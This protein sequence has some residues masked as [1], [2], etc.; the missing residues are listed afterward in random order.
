MTTLTFKNFEYNIV[1]IDPTIEVAGDGSTPATALNTFPNSLVNNTCYIIRR[2]AKENYAELVNATNANLNNLIIMGMPKSR[3]SDEYTILPQ[4]VKD[5]WGNDTE[6]Y[7][8][9]LANR[10]LVILNIKNFSLLNTFFFRNTED[11]AEKSTGK[12]AMFM[13]YTSSSNEVFYRDVNVYI[14]GCKFGH[15]YYD[16]SDATYQEENET[17][18]NNYARS[19]MRYLFFGKVNNLEIQD[20]TF[21]YTCDLGS[22]SLL[23]NFDSSGYMHINGDRSNNQGVNAAFIFTPT[24]DIILK[25]LVLNCRYAH[26]LKWGIDSSPNYMNYLSDILYGD[27]SY[28]CSRS[29]LGILDIRSNTAKCKIKNI[30]INHILHSDCYLPCNPLLINSTS[31]HLRSYYGGT[32]YRT[33][34]LYYPHIDMSDIDIYMSKF[35]GANPTTS[36]TALFNEAKPTNSTLSNKALERDNSYRLGSIVLHGIFEGTVKN[37]NADLTYAPTMSVLT[38]D[39]WGGVYNNCADGKKLTIKNINVNT[40][41]TEENIVYQTQDWNDSYVL[42]VLH[43]EFRSGNDSV[44]MRN[45][46][47]INPI[48]LENIYINSPYGGALNL[49]HAEIKN[50]TIIGNTKFGYK[51]KAK[52]DSLTNCCHHKPA[53]YIMNEENDIEIKDLIFDTTK[54][55]GTITNTPQVCYDKSLSKFYGNSSI[56]IENSN[57]LCFEETVNTTSNYDDKGTVICVNHGQEGQ[58]LQVTKNGKINSCSVVR[59]GSSANASLRFILNGI[60]EEGFYQTIKNDNRSTFTIYPESTG[61]ISVSFFLLSEQPLDNEDL[62]DNFKIE[63]SHRGENGTIDSVLSTSI[64]EDSSTWTGLAGGY[65]YKITRQLNIT[66]IENPLEIEVKNCISGKGA[67]YLDPDIQVEEQV[68]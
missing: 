62:T 47:S 27:D 57:A 18:P 68:M 5:A 48:Y 67:I 11:T 9:V 6:A 17:D 31:A 39:N 37:I 21:D 46:P 7:A 56:V 24:K 60:N 28:T 22:N 33:A 35:K 8:N 10:T 51:A 50:A 54:A 42:N 12:S 14:K 38:V 59:E 45:R 1:Y 16:M 66:S 41:Q 44:G 65:A 43:H 64:E 19:C 26:E 20:S 30:S 63:I 34:A 52:L 36:Y 4:E 15:F 2:T 3:F 25:N 53:V 49:T 58:F 61:D 13:H 55:W 23:T 29:A 32:N 40:A